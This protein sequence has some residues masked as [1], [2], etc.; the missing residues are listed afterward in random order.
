MTGR[1]AARYARGLQMAQHG[2]NPKALLV[3]TTCGSA[4]RASA[5]AE[6]LVR[7]HLA[8]CV[9]AIGAV[10]ST[11]WWQDD[12]EHATETLVLIKTTAARYGEVEAV[13][14]ELSEYELPEIVA[15]EIAG[16]LD[17]YLEWIRHTTARVR[18]N[19]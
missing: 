16:G 4:T 2:R 18:E 8:A 7:R 12:V 3:L 11:Y 15:I 17:G 19:G 5:L 14:R 9:N 1:G 13:I 10:E 6:Q